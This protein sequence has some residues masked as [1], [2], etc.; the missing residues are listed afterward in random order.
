MSN[1][2]IVSHPACGRHEAGPGHPEQPGR[3][4]A[5]LSALAALDNVETIEAPKADRSVLELAH[6]PGHVDE[7]H[8]RAPTDGL[9]R[10]DADTIMSP[11]SLEA[12]SRAA[13]AVVLAVDRV[14]DQGGRAFCPVRPPGHHAERGRAMGFCLFNNIAI[15]AAYALERRGLERV[16]IVD[17]D[18]HHGNGTEEIVAGD[19]RVL[20]C[21]SF[22]HPFYPYSGV[23]PLASNILNV[24]LPAGTAGATFRRTVADAWRA[25]LDEFRPQL[26]LIS[27]GFDAHAADPIG[28]LELREPDYAWVTQL[29]VDVAERH[30]E[31]RIVSALEGG[32]QLE[33][34]G[35]SALSHA[36]TL[37]GCD[38][39]R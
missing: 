26:L 34:L 24:P 7:I 16:A 30:A 12:A 14:L 23:P 17:F 22:Q 21:S 27:A 35:Q 8:H 39:A 13:G 1:L 10:L 31:G 25:A 5:V 28:G 9:V 4:V 2:A 32:Y 38:G 36:R 19:R 15:G 20:F 33:A 29:V 6:E 3:L 18:V 11:H 37:A